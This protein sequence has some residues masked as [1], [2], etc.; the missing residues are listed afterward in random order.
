MLS[1][2]E[3][4][5]IA[6]ESSFIA[7]VI[8]SLVTLFLLLYL[9]YTQ[10]QTFETGDNATVRGCSSHCSPHD[11]DLTCL[12]RSLEFYERLLLAQMK[13]FIAVQMHIDQWYKWHSKYGHRN[14]TQTKE[15]VIAKL[16]AQLEPEDVIDEETIAT[17]V[18]VLID[19]VEKGTETIE[20][21][22]PHFTC[23]LPCEYRYDIWRNVFIASMTLNL[24][25]VIALVP[26][27][28]SL[29]RSDVPEQLVRT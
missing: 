12:T 10:A 5:K 15:E 9:A 17:V 19:N 14:Y 1:E 6:C 27:I 21:E 3:K 23:P 28:V 22:I 24:L 18:D 13:H 25:L 16:S 26:F 11:S 7:R 2:E 8:D 20:A 29:I 4:D